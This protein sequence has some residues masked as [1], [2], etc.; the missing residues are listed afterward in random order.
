M[1]PHLYQEKSQP[2]ALLLKTSPFFLGINVSLRSEKA[3]TNISKSKSRL[4]N[5][6]PKID[7]VNPRYLL[8][9]STMQL[10][11]ANENMYAHVNHKAFQ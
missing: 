5:A 11:E 1:I 4:V 6:H 8:F 9:S 10:S 3:Y 2:E 7:Q